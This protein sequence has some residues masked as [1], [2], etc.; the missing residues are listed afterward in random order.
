M[1]PPR[2]SPGNIS[3]GGPRLCLMKYDQIRREDESRVLDG[4]KAAEEIL[5]LNRRSPQ[6]NLPQEG[7]WENT[8]DESSLSPNLSTETF[9]KQRKSSFGISLSALKRTLW[10]LPRSM[11]FS[12]A[13]S[14]ERDGPKPRRRLAC[15]TIEIPLSVGDDFSDKSEADNPWGVTAGYPL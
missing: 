13:S 6:S 15:F 10:G 12:R 5:L 9:S 14:A 11:G 1:L 2:K 3:F 8:A 7:P 4:F